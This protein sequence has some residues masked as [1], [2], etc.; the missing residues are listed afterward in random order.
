MQSLINLFKRNLKVTP[1]DF[2]PT[3]AN[4][5][6]IWQPKEIKHSA[7]RVP[8]LSFDEALETASASVLSEEA[9]ATAGA[10]IEGG[11]AEAPED[12]EAIGDDNAVGIAASVEPGQEP[13]ETTLTEEDVPA[14]QIG[15]ADVEAAFQRGHDAATDEL[16]AE[17]NS[18]RGEFAGSLCSLQELSAQLSS[19]YCSEAVELAA[20]IAK[21]VVGRELKISPETMVKIV[22]DALSEVPESA[23]IV[24]RCHPE[25]LELMQ[26]QVPNL[27]Q[28]HGA[29][30]SIRTAT[31]QEVERGGC[32][33]QF[34]E[35]AVDAQPS[36]S[37]DVLKEAVEAS[38]AGRRA[39]PNKD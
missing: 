32:V 5:P 20:V 11:A 26:A 9:A 13:L 25:D 22:Q 28:R 21:A 19:R 34:E 33:I 37:V 6:T 1:V 35:G 29:P 18:L 7:K 15:K 4:E 12:G 17:I 2:A 14:A 36:V 24:I 23:E 8:K 27:T 31:G 3:E 30:V 16:N 38:L 39:I 10:A